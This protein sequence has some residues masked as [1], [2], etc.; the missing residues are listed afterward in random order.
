MKLF[1]DRNRTLLP[2]V[3]V[4][5]LLTRIMTF[6]GILWFVSV[7]TY[8]DYDFTLFVAVVA[9]YII[10]LV[11]FGFAIRGTFDLKMAYLSAII[12]DLIFV[13]LLIT[14]TG[15]VSSTFYLVFFLTAAVAAY[16]LTFWFATTVTIVVTG[17]YLA[18]LSPT[19]EVQDIFS[20][21]MRLGFLW[22]CFL[23]ISYGS[24]YLRRSEARLLKLFDTLNMRTA[25]LEKSQAQLEM[26]Y[27]NTRILAS[28]LEPN[29]IITEVIRIM[30]ETLGFEH[31]AIIFRNQTGEFYYRARL[32]DGHS[33][34]H[35]K[36]ISQGRKEL[37]TRVCTQAE[38]VR[39]KDLKGRT[40]YESLKAGAR[41]AIV[42][43]MTAHGRTL[44]LLTAESTAPD[45]YSDK[46]VQ[47]LTIVARSAGLALEN[48]ELHKRT[49][50]LTVIDDLTQAYN[51]RFFIRKLQEEKKRAIRYDLPL[52]I[53]MVDIDWFKKLN[54]SY[55]HEAGNIVLKQLSEVIKGCVR[56]TDYFARYGGEEFVVILPQ[57]PQVEAS[58]IGERIRVKVQNTVIETGQAGRVKITV[59]VGVSSFPENGKSAEDL[60]SVADQA[61]YRAKGSGKNLVC[62]V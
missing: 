7:G 54:D 58:A 52:S 18:I 23:V 51:Y 46:D 3:D 41:S 48:A 8:S 59:S 22:V 15:G 57:T 40:D 13:P 27:E 53:I 39:V 38:A 56:D 16:L 43:P 26:N 50:E 20:V 19:M 28:L 21:S 42:V 10:H 30:G 33:N 44:G 61:L 60:V 4:I 62:I 37:I 17:V 11:Y 31:C 36:A 45:K 14:Y 12:Y 24:E 29:A 25:E 35:L 32:V 47:M 34:F 49:E 1:L 6:L 55:G 5:Y 9:T 2:R